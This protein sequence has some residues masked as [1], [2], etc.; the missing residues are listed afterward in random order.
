MI[1]C[2]TYECEFCHT[3]YKSPGEAEACEAVHMLPDRNIKFEYRT[4]ANYPYRVVLTFE[5]GK[6][7]WYDSRGMEED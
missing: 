5:D 7:V 1:E 6:K 2:V 3:H 4:G